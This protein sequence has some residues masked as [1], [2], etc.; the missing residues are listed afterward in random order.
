MT[1]KPKPS[2]VRLPLL[3]LGGL[4][5]VVFFAVVVYRPDRPVATIVPGSSSGPAFVVQIIRPRVGLPLGG[6]LPPELFGLDEHLGFDSAST[7][8]TIG[9]VGPERLEL[10]AD[11]WELVI[12]LDGDGRVTA[13]THVV[14]ELV[15]EE[16]PR[17]LRG[18]PG[19]PIVGTFSRTVPADSGELSGSFDI[20]LARCEDAD[21][22][23]PL[24]WPSQPLV[25][26]GS[27]DRLPLGAGEERP[28][29]H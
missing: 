14:F 29:S 7:G 4:F 5:V 20:E 25:L 10:A 21:T 12:V 1:P 3:L 16:R 9:S 6:I 2:R 24:G 22:R 17:K 8:A 11:D 27:F 18:W 23:A 13:E 15:F 26:H 28:P 19:D